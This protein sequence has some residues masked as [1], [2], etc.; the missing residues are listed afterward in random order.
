MAVMDNQDVVSV[1]KATINELAI[2]EGLKIAKFERGVCLMD[3][4]GS[5]Q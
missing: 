1:V 3:C 2:N 5:L 4:F